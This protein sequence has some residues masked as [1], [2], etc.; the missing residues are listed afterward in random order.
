MAEGTA[1]SSPSVGHEVIVISDDENDSDSNVEAPRS[2]PLS[3][4]GVAEKL[5][6]LAKHRE[7]RVDQQAVA[8]LLQDTGVP[9]STDVSGSLRL[10]CDT[11]GDLLAFSRGHDRRYRASEDLVWVLC[12]VLS[13]ARRQSRE[14]MEQVKKEEHGD[15]LR[16]LVQLMEKWRLM[17]EECS[18]TSIGRERALNGTIA[19]L[20]AMVGACSLEI[21][22]IQDD[23]QDYEVLMETATE[24]WVEALNYCRNKLEDECIEDIERSWGIFDDTFSLTGDVQAQYEES[25]SSRS[26][27]VRQA[28]EVELRRGFY[29]AALTLTYTITQ[30][31]DSRDQ[32]EQQQNMTPEEQV[33][34]LGNDVL[35]YMDTF[36]EGLRAVCGNLPGSTRGV[37]TATL[38]DENRLELLSFCKNFEAFWLVHRNWLPPVVVDI[39]INRFATLTEASGRAGCPVS[40]SIDRVCASLQSG[41]LH[42][43]ITSKLLSKGKPELLSDF[44]AVLKS[45]AEEEE[46][47]RLIFATF[48]VVAVPATASAFSPDGQ[49]RYLLGVENVLLCTQLNSGSFFYFIS[50]NLEFLMGPKTS[51]TIDRVLIRDRRSF[52]K[53]Q[54][55]S[56]SK[57][58]RPSFIT[59]TE[60]LGWRVWLLILSA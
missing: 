42:F 12:E 22:H 58:S 5:L 41:S 51:V 25:K 30:L 26:A 23:M 44:C 40:T 11:L 13:L 45:A 38:E 18:R 53:I 36:C 19:R 15:V 21:A 52:R 55:R 28:Q 24:D 60:V 8:T 16:E 4:P 3:W 43:E 17:L 2:Q 10:A 9:V 46:L 48:A 32:E 37:A 57:K 14:Q 39:V 6:L 56:R 33:N 7:L 29:Q 20:E 31:M 1:A 54:Q 34:F 59:I 47:D 27:L 50:K 35:V 49:S